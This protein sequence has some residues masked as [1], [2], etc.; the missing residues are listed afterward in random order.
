VSFTLV[1]RARNSAS[2]GR[3]L[4]AAFLS[5]GVWFFS[6]TLSTGAFIEILQGKMGWKVSILA[7][8]FYAV[9]TMVGSVA[10]HWWSLRSERGKSSV[11][12]NAKYAQIP[13]EEWD[14]CLRLNALLVEDYKLRCAPFRASEDGKVVSIEQAKKPR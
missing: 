6:Q 13:V 11:G 4:K 1:S 14:T 7:G 9:T 3:H 8:L 2:L 12:A 10:A 5:N